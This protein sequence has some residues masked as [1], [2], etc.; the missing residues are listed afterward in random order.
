[1]VIRVLAVNQS[2]EGYVFSSPFLRVMYLFSNYDNRIDFNPFHW[3]SSQSSRFARQW[4]TSSLLNQSHVCRFNPLLPI[5]EVWMTLPASSSIWGRAF[6]SPSLSHFCSLRHWYFAR[7]RAWTLMV[8]SV[9]AIWLAVEFRR[10]FAFD[11]SPGATASIKATPDCH[12]WNGFS[13]DLGGKAALCYRPH[14][15]PQQIQ[16]HMLQQ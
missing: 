12:L 7:K 11:V 1:M 5:H 10:Q 13:V 4:D 3:T 2:S 14:D 6:V 15:V 9:F 16:I 8:E